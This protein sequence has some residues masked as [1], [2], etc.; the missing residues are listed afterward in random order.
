MLNEKWIL[1]E[2]L[3]RQWHDFLHSSQ[4]KYIA[5]K[6]SAL[7]HKLFAQDTTEFS[8]VSRRLGNS[9]LDIIYQD[10][11]PSF[12]VWRTSPQNISKAIRQGLIEYDA[13]TTKAISALGTYHHAVNSRAY[14]SG[15][16]SDKHQ[17]KISLLNYC[18]SNIEALQCLERQI[19]R[20]PPLFKAPSRE[21]LIDCLNQYQADLT[22]NLA[23]LFKHKAD[24]AHTDSDFERSNLSHH[25][26]QLQ[27]AKQLIEIIKSQPNL[28]YL[29]QAEAP[30]G[31]LSFIKTQILNEVRQVQLHNQNITY[32][33]HSKSW[34]RGCLN[35]VCEDA[36]K[37]VNDYV[38]DY[39]NPILAEHQGHFETK[40][41]ALVSISFESIKE[42]PRLFKQTLMAVC[43]IEQLDL[44]S[45][46]KDNHYQ[47]KLCNGSHT[48]L[49]QTPYTKW[50]AA[51]ANGYYA[52]RVLFW[53]WNVFSGIV[54]GLAIDLPV[55]LLFGLS[56]NK[57]KSIAHKAQLSIKNSSFY[58][59][60]FGYLFSLFQPTKYA[61][62][63]L[64][65]LKVITFFKNLGQDLLKSAST[66]AKQYKL[67]LW[68]NLIADYRIG[69]QPAVSTTS[70]L[71]QLSD[72]F[73]ALKQNH[74][75]IEED[76]LNKAPASYQNYSPPTT[77]YQQAKQP[78]PLNDGEWMDLSNSVAHGFQMFSSA[79]TH[80]IHT[81]NPFLGLLFCS[82]Y[83][84]TGL[85]ILN[86]NAVSFLPNWFVNHCNNLAKALAK[87]KMTGAAGASSMQS[88]LTVSSLEA[89]L[90]GNASWLAT[91]SKLFESDPSKVLVYM[92][93]SVSLG[94]L[95][96]FKLNIPIISKAI[97]EDL[98]KVPIPSLGVA[99]AKLGFLF[100]HL[101]EEREHPINREQA[102]LSQEQVKRYI[103]EN[104]AESFDEQQ[105][106]TLT[107][108][109][110][111]LL[112]N[113]A[114]VDKLING[115]N[116]SKEDQ[117]QAFLAFLKQQQYYLAHLSPMSK[118]LIQD[119]VKALFPQQAQIQLSIEKQL[120]PETHQ[121]ILTVTILTPLNYIPLIFRC[122]T[123]PITHSTAPFI[124]LY[125]KTQKDLT[126]LLNAAA[127]FSHSVASLFKVFSKM[128]FEII[129]NEVLARAE[130][131][132]TKDKH[133][134]ASSNYKLLKLFDASFEQTKAQAGLIVNQQKR[135]CT[136]PST[137]AL[138]Q[139]INQLSTY[140]DKS[141]ATEQ[142]NHDA[143]EP[144]P[145]PPHTHAF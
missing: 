64:V 43:Q 124:D 42:N 80:P 36:I 122:L 127:S 123:T 78:Y 82:T 86:P 125:H 10:H 94:A 106:A 61:L 96:A 133:H 85:S 135:A 107:E 22:K 109:F 83:F 45:K 110:T 93:L 115:I 100:V 142:V 116:L 5:S 126:R 145:E 67:E 87:G 113:P 73:K 77:R 39:H 7:P 137:A 20:A 12:Y 30:T 63:T 72:E 1:R 76:I 19:N 119:K 88:Q 23:E 60:H 32:S 95:I 51:N 74:Q 46:D 71:K 97:R 70:L 16:I 13:L 52:Y 21:Y 2:K 38:L 130:S 57:M 105:L 129:F 3:A 9:F 92:T 4:K 139:N 132:L 141:L 111:N 33:G 118:R 6:P 25:Q 128:L 18:Q 108:L 8:K 104:A 69:H 121:S 53:L 90:N 47:L 55:G 144:L 102:K 34:L 81:K 120:Y 58:H 117:R 15:I 91:G 114:Q 11:E 35:D 28:A 62:G 29:L 140:E 59:T 54:L 26:S 112:N 131:H 75:H 41:D 68:D 31:L 17:A 50:S 99:G 101:L 103:R 143:A 65:G 89:C 14:E 44:I 134:I 37:V 27:A 84:V 40:P 136:Y 56:G 98:G 138:Y 48:P 66:S 49:Q 79:L 24:F